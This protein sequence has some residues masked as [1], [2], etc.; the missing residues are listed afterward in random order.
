MSESYTKLFSTITA[1]TIWGEPLATRVVWIT[2]LAMADKHGQ[3]MASV[4][5]LARIAN[6][7]LED[8]ESA[9]KTLRSPDPYSRTPD[10]EGRRIEDVPGGWFLLNYAAY[11]ERMSKEDRREQQ[12]LWAAQKRER[13][14]M[15]TA[16]VD[17][18]TGG[19][20]KST[21]STHTEAEAKAEESKSVD[22]AHLEDSSPPAPDPL[23]ADGK[24][25]EAVLSA[26]HEA[27]PKCQR[28]GVLNPKRRR[29]IL[30][31]DKLARQVC[32]QQGWKWDREWFWGNY[33][34]ECASDPW[35]RGEVPNPNNP[36]W[37]QNL[38]VLLAEDRFAKI[39]DG[40]VSA[41]GPA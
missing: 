11:R 1:S 30:A 38:D 21:K 32:Q 40:V 10:F 13:D 26:Y 25:C 37:R 41:E 7:S 12:R 19:V 3:V 18:S 35:M 6:V 4:P 8:C 5:G 2:M 9:L 33:F 23:S 17:A 34:G 24:V 27:L 36:K 22:A 15:S 39:M 14:R 29:R 31:A 16:N 28:V 20:D